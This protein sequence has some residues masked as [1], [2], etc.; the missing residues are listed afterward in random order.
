MIQYNQPHPIQSRDRFLKK[1]NQENEH[2]LEYCEI[3][4]EYCVFRLLFYCISFSIIIYKCVYYKESYL[5]FSDFDLH[6]NFTI[7]MRQQLDDFSTLE[8]VV[9][10]MQSCKHILFI[11]GIHYTCC[12][13]YSYYWHIVGAGVSVSCGIPGR[14]L[15]HNRSIVMMFELDFRSKNGIYNTMEIADIGIPSAELLFDLDFFE[16]DPEPFYKYAHKLIPPKTAPSLSHSFIG[17]L[18]E[19]NKLLRNYTQNVDGLERRAN[20]SRLVECH[21]TMN[22]FKCMKCRKKVELRAV[23]DD[24]ISQKV[25]VCH[26]C[27]RGVMVRCCL[28]YSHTMHNGYRII[29]YNSISHNDMTRNR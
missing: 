9:K 3:L 20:I 11:T 8:D 10:A 23:V 27:K 21:G 15:F 7:A 2:I 4:Q 26:A 17:L 16:T 12:Q 14:P 24:I 5:G 22:R 18:E 6:T 19:K 13:R 1:N 29:V 28:L 25:P